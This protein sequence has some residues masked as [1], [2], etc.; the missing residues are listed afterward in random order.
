PLVSPACLSTH[1]RLSHSPPHHLLLCPALPHAPT[2]F[3]PSLQVPP[4]SSPSTE[5]TQDLSATGQ[6][7]RDTAFL[8][9]TARPFPPPTISSSN[10]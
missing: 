2:F 7:Q 1:P 9:P 5:P 6:Q 3:T 10:K 4:S 8:R